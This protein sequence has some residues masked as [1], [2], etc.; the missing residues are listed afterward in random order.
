MKINRIFAGLLLAMSL[1]PMLGHAADFNLI[2]RPAELAEGTGSFAFGKSTAVCVQGKDAQQVAE[3]FLKKV[4]ASTGWDLALSDKRPKTGYVSFVVDSRFRS[5][6]TSTSNPDSESEAYRLS[7]T[8]NGVTLMAS[9]SDGLFR[10]MQTLLQL[11]PPEVEKAGGAKGVA[12][13]EVPA[14]D[15]NDAPRFSYRG[16]MLDPCR[17][18]LPAE[19]VKRQ[20]DMLAT[21]KFN[22]LHWH[23]TEDQGWRV[24]S[25]RHPELNKLGSVRTEGDGSTYGGYYTKDE[26]RDVVA[27]A[28]ERHMEVIPELEMPGHEL[29]AIATY[30]NLSCRGESITP[31][32]IWGVEDI[33]MCPGKEDMFRFLEDEIDEFVELFPSKYFHIGGDESP[34]EE[35]AQCPNCQKRMKDLG[36]TKEAQ[37]QDYIIERMAKYLAS[38]GKTIIG[39]DEILEGG[40]LD[41][42]A[43]VMSWR[44][45]EGG[46]TAAKMNHHVLMTPGSHGLYFDHFQG[47]PITEP[48]AIGGYSTLEKVYSY[49]PVPAELHEQGKDSYVLGVQAN[50]WSEYIHNSNVLEYRLYPRALAL[51]E[52][53]WSPLEGRSFADFQRRCDGDGALRLEAH[54]MN[55]HIPVPEQ[56]GAQCNNI[57]FLDSYTLE[58]TTTRPVRIVYTTDTAEPTATSAEYTEPL[59]FTTSTVVKARC[60]LPSGAMGAV[61]TFNIKKDVWHKAVECPKQKCPTTCNAEAPKK[62]KNRQQCHEADAICGQQAMPQPVQGVRMR[63]AYGNYT[64]NGNVPPCAWTIDSIA[65]RLESVRN[66]EK[67]P[68]SVRNVKNYAATAECLVDIPEDGIYEFFTLN[69]ALWL[70]GEMLV[71]NRDLFIPRMSY[72]GTQIA[73]KAG[74]HRLKTL[75][76]GGIFSGWPSYWDAANVRYRKQGVS[77]FTDIKPEQCS[78][79][80]QHGRPMQACGNMPQKP[81]C[82]KNCKKA[83]CKKDCK[84][85]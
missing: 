15:I 74:K 39:W 62:G 73:L 43:V 35:W 84:K 26:I 38:K 83:D 69:S 6:V 7:V 4:N 21:L 29:A 77:E 12:A 53:A 30:P 10:G 22:R 47:D 31:R 72:N 1:A 51:S 8:K 41:P 32:I 19:D 17:H 9:T 48:N 28:K 23:L 58:L 85:H 55:F 20:I 18:W 27:Y 64:F 37:L 67:V 13:W 2:P 57:A 50:N 68:A 78:V 16:I 42:S 63:V 3:F 56:K 52:V 11:L 76:V 36:L 71:D 40:N 54:G 81:Y 79:L 24:E 14:V 33:V 46:I 49:D 70:D 44:G 61:R 66:V 82:K 65:P 34:R 80:P 60:I 25:T 45:E 59:T 75:F 5:G